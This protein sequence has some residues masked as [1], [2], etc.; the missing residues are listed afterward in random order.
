MHNKLISYDEFTK[1]NSML[2]STNKILV[3]CL[4]ELD[5]SHFGEIQLLDVITALENISASFMP[6]VNFTNLLNSFV[7][8]SK[9][10]TNQP[11]I[12][13]HILKGYAR[14]AKNLQHVDSI[15]VINYEQLFNA[16]DKV[17]KMQQAIEPFTKYIEK[18]DIDNYSRN[19]EQALKSI[20]T[21]NK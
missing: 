14:V 18:I 8:A 21:I 3:K 6:S 12:T 5:K 17:A 13:E 15:P 19:M 9:D 10:I 16:H 11:N 7:S 1:C 2:D 20:S 4:C